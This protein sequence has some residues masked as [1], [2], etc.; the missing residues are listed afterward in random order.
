MQASSPDSQ[1][2]WAWTLPGPP[3]GDD[4][5]ES[6]PDWADEL[7]GPVAE[8]PERRWAGELISPF[9][10]APVPEQAEIVP[11]DSENH[12]TAGEGTQ[13][14]P[15][16]VEGELSTWAA[17]LTQAP[18]EV[19]TAL[20][21]VDHLEEEA[22]GFLGNVVHYVQATNAVHNA[23]AGGEL[24]E[25]KLTDIGYRTFPGGGVRIKAGDPAERKEQWRRIRDHVVRPLL[26]LKKT[27]L[28]RL[29]PRLRPFR[30]A[31]CALFVPVVLD[32][33]S[34]GVHGTAPVDALGEVYTRKLGFID[35]GHARETADVTLWALTQLQQHATVGTVIDLFHG[36]ARLL[37][38]IPLERRLALAQQLTYVDSVEHE[39]VTVGTSQDYSAFS[40]EDLP[41]NLFGTLVA[42]AAFR[43]D[44][45]SD[46]AITQQFKQK[47][48]AADAQSVAVARQVQ[49]TAE[50][51]GWWQGFSLRKR[52]F[53]ANP[54][55]IDEH[56]SA[57]IG[58][59]ALPPAPSLVSAEFEYESATKPLKNSEFAQ[60]I[61][62]I[63][64]G[65][66]ASAMT[67]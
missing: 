7:D 45:G 63:R 29:V 61:A 52:N 4:T 23:L 64:A 28:D 14:R 33:P 5:L 8:E 46:T 42:V 39:I 15:F 32:V 26:R 57:R 19:R 37:R 30:R 27:G 43:A 62:T 16:S 25:N 34:L 55:L 12:A 2:A 49:I 54:W 40:P 36:S 24:N 21:S 53:T 51:R 59:G 31:C 3:M 56:G 38:D 50:N 58:T 13:P 20:S 17:E 66:P 11:H 60:E 18:Q 41:S 35:M 47:L 6:A 10:A 9:A 22:E 67:P 44:G 1:A 48:Q 65:F